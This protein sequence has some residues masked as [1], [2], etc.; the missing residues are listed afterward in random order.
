MLGFSKRTDYGILALAYLAEIPEGERANARQLAEELS[1]PPELLAKVL[2]SMVKVGFVNSQMGPGGGY[3]LA[4]SPS[5]ITIADVVS[6]I[7][8]PITL[9]ECLDKEAECFLTETCTIRRPM[10]MIQEK[11]VEFLKT[12]TLEDMWSTQEGIEQH[13]AAHLHG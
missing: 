10:G 11:L 8:G 1:V 2:Q 5:D 6:A 3:N 7:E 4:W 13:E 12:I 9:T